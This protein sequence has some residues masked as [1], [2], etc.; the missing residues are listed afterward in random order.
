[1]RIAVRDVPVR[2]FQRRMEIIRERAAC[3]GDKQVVVLEA[4]PLL[5]RGDHRV[6]DGPTRARLCFWVCLLRGCLRARV[7]R[8]R[9]DN[10]VG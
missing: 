8:H 2:A 5:A 6:L 4:V 7:R 1:M 3:R 9:Q 10:A